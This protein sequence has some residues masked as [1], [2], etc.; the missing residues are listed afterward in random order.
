MDD[1]TLRENRA[2]LFERDECGEYDWP[3]THPPIISDNVC[4]LIPPHFQV[5]Q[6]RPAEELLKVHLAAPLLQNII[7]DN[8]SSNNN[9]IWKQ[10]SGTSRENT[11]AWWHLD[12]DNIAS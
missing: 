6:A 2:P 12:A 10:T 9:R 11:A 3:L 8:K 4:C 1:N 7:F 5:H